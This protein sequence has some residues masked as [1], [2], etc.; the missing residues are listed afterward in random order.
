[1][2]VQLYFLAKMVFLY[3][4]YKKKKKM[5]LTSPPPPP[6]ITTNPFAGKYV[7]IFCIIYVNGVL[8]LEE[9]PTAKNVSSGRAQTLIF[10]FFVCSFENPIFQYNAIIS[11]SKFPFQ[12]P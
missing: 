6:L 1:M 7:H 11:T 2:T 10:G 9:F 12:G 4:T 3:N 8:E 5:F